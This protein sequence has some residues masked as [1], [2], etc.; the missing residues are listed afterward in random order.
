MRMRIKSSS[1]TFTV[2]IPLTNHDTLHLPV[3]ILHQSMCPMQTNNII[4]VTRIVRQMKTV[5]PE[6]NVESEAP[7][8][9]G[10]RDIISDIRRT[11]VCLVLLAVLLWEIFLRVN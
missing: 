5:T 8:P 10:L 2:A 7:S 6:V 3:P 4:A 9:A 11:M 1:L